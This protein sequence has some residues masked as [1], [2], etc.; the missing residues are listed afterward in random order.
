MKQ[1]GWTEQ[2]IN[3]AISLGKSYSASNNITPSNGA[4]RYIHPN[5]GRSV[6]IDNVTKNIIHVGGDSFK[7]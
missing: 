7:Y 5:T 4:T 6:V 2:Q 1:R 3:E